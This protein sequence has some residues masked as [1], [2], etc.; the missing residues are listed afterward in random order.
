MMVAGVVVFKHIVLELQC[1]WLNN[2]MIHM[3]YFPV[4]P[5][6][7]GVVI[8]TPTFGFYIATLIYGLTHQKVLNG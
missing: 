5:V 7:S 2:W 6:T 1:L 3:W 8:A 4:C